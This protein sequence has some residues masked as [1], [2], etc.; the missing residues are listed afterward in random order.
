MEQIEGLSY[1]LSDAVGG[2]GYAAE[3]EAAGETLI[4]G[5]ADVVEG[6]LQSLGVIPE[7][8]EASPLAFGAFGSVV[9]A[10][11]TFNGVLE[12][13]D[14]VNTMAWKFGIGKPEAISKPEPKEGEDEE[15]GCARK[16]DIQA[17]C[18]STACV[19][20]KEDENPKCTVVSLHVRR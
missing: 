8:A 2:E 16:D 15:K 4:F 7:L 11:V 17:P 6:A 1:E 20:K 19:G 12:D 14:S 9:V 10:A 18:G 5:G 3:L 13:G